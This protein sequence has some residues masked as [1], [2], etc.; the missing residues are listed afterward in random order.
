MWPGASSPVRSCSSTLPPSL[1]KQLFLLASC[2]LRVKGV[3]EAVLYGV[4][5]FSSL[6][7]FR[8]SML[9]SMDSQ[10]GKDLKNHVVSLVDLDTDLNVSVAAFA[11][12]GINRGVKDVGD[13]RVRLRLPHPIRVIQF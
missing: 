9:C 10:V 12:A 11:H 3:S 2:F 7:A 1:F 6:S 13:S 8:V 4:H 5:N